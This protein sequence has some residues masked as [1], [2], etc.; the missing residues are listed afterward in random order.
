MGQIDIAQE[1][2]YPEL[3][4]PIVLSRAFRF[5]WIGN[6]L[7]IFGS[8]I[9]NVMLPLLVYELTD[10]PMVMSMIMMAYILPEVL[11]LPISGIIVDRFNRAKIMRTTDLIRFL[12][13]IGVMMLGLA[14]RLSISTLVATVAVMGLMTGLFEPAFSAMRATIFVPAIRNSANALNQGTQQLL[15]LLGPA[16]GGLIVSLASVSL[17]FGLD[18]LTY[19]ISFLC[20]LCLT[21]EGRIAVSG[22]RR[23]TSLISECLEGIRI[24]KRRTWLWVTILF[25]SFINI[26]VSGVILILVPWLVKVHD[27]FPPYIYG[28]VMSGSALGSIGVAF[29]FGLRRKWNRR[30]L[31]A[32]GAGIFT[33]IALLLMPLVDHAALLIALM[34]VVGAG[35]MLFGLI[36]ETSLQELVA[37]EVFGRVASIDMVGSFALLPVGYL[38]TGW[39]A[40]LIGGVA[41]ILSLSGLVIVAHLLILLVPEIRKYD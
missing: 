25:Y 5:L 27:Q 9:T 10:S 20:L 35:N 18:G 33:G 4:R 15:Q 21:Q 38:M 7:S 39:L 32:Y 31:L 2:H 40:E 34:V 41:T 37:P 16:A 19:L 36:W 13:M 6:S 14:G 22:Q 3:L 24:I 17:G 23:P 8:A 12:L 28:I 29:L 26:C 11:I 30:G 1:K